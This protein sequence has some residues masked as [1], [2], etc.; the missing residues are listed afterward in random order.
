ME[1]IFLLP[2]GQ[3]SKFTSLSLSGSEPEFFTRSGRWGNKGRKKRH[4]YDREPDAVE[5]YLA[6]I[7]DLCESGHAEIGPW[8]EFRRGDERVELLAPH[9]LAQVGR[10]ENGRIKLE[11]FES[12]FD[13]IRRYGELV[14]SIRGQGYTLCLPTYEPPPTSLYEQILVYEEGDPARLEK[15]YWRSRQDPDM[16]R[17]EE[18]WYKEGSLSCLNFQLQTK[19]QGPCLYFKDNALQTV[20]LAH[21]DNN[22]N[23]YYFFHPDGRLRTFGPVE[24]GRRAGVWH[25]LEQ[26]NKTTLRY[27]NG[28]VVSIEWARLDDTLEQTKLFDETGELR[29][30]QYYDDDG[31]L[32]RS[33]TRVEGAWSVVL[34]RADGVT[35]RES[36]LL[37]EDGERRGVWTEYDEDGVEVVALSPVGE[38]FSCMERGEYLPTSALQNTHRSS[39]GSSSAIRLDLPE[40]LEDH[41]GRLLCIADGGLEALRPEGAKSRGVWRHTSDAGSKLELERRKGHLVGATLIRADGTRAAT[42]TYRQSGCSV[43]VLHEDGERSARWGDY[44]TE[45]RWSDEEPLEIR[46]VG[47][48]FEQSISGQTTRAQRFESGTY[49]VSVDHCFD[50]QTPSL[51][52]EA[53]DAFFGEARSLASQSPSREQFLKICGLVE[54]A[55][56]QDAAR[57]AAEL[58]PYLE[59]VVSAWSPRIRFAPLLWI[60]RL[61]RGAL[62]VEALSLVSALS[63]TAA[64]TT[65]YL[66]SQNY[67]LLL[68]WLDT[69]PE[70]GPTLVGIS[71]SFRDDVASALAAA[72]NGQPELYHPD[73]DLELDE[74]FHLNEDDY[75]LVF[76]SALFREVRVLDFSW[77]PTRQDFDRD[78]QGILDGRGLTVG[79]VMAFVPHPEH[80]EVLDLWGQLNEPGDQVRGYRSSGL[81]KGA[82]GGLVELNVG[83]GHPVGETGLQHI[84]SLC[85]NLERLSIRP[86][87][88]GNLLVGYDFDE[89][90]EG[91][92]RDSVYGRIHEHWR[93]YGNSDIEKMKIERAGWR[94]LGKL[95]SLAFVCMGDVQE[96]HALPDKVEV[97]SLSEYS[98]ADAPRVAAWDKHFDV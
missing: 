8:L 29:A 63:L 43:M 91:S 31:I 67:P 32:T 26:D 69:Y 85:P 16:E 9:V 97:L 33:D 76:G 12:V 50:V 86:G 73:G 44:E 28:L 13:A 15:S 6:Y 19:K 22:Y 35:P 71:M 78:D 38:L 56:E 62:P 94:A 54:R 20:C 47:W 90:E 82:L 34:Y 93:V 74:D 95:G 72:K 48:W 98:H 10:R 57:A 53:F 96:P 87:H 17:G 46:R 21:R 24:G 41:L 89:W 84:A 18:R 77:E 75:P 37:G 68:R 51:A 45:S 58:I 1:R 40:T 60:T 80:V 70:D 49:D 7:D 25:E 55:S 61:I 36:G 39:Y 65:H 11:T 23:Q 4:R 83:G 79:D 88:A 2:D 3:D 66:S 81:K 30:V 64:V 27:Q 42:A 92:G 14:T 59:Q 52:P 5:A